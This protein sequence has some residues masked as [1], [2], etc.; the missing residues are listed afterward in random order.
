MHQCL[1]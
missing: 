1:I